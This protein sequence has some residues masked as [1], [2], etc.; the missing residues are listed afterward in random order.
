MLA[1]YI[2]SDSVTLLYKR[3]ELLWATVP[4]LLYFIAR[5]W[6]ACGR[7]ELHDDPVVYL[8]RTPSTYYVLLA[9]LLVVIAAM[10]NWF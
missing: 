1:L 10:V 7:G 3:P 5:L 2:N 8:T 6:V 4:L 9:V